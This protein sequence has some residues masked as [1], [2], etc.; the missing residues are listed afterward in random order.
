VVAFFSASVAGTFLA[1]FFALGLE[2]FSASLMGS[3][4]RI[5][6]S[7]GRFRRWLCLSGGSLDNAPGGR[8]GSSRLPG[9]AVPRTGPRGP[10]SRQDDRFLLKNRV[11]SVLAW[12]APPSL[13][14]M[15]HDGGFQSTMEA[16]D[17]AGGCGMPRC[18]PAMMN[19]T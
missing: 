14:S 19:S 6:G 16:L 13:L 15:T 9:S 11:E 4:T 5:Q 12:Q 3:A 10:P 18:C 2:T 8:R 1:V 7:C 17:E